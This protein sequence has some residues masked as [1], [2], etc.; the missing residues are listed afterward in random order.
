M[1]ADLILNSK[2]KDVHAFNGLA[3]LKPEEWKNIPVCVVNAMKNIV[4]NND[5]L[6]GKIKV[7]A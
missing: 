2:F 4:E 7:L 1:E 6:L 3:H 5:D